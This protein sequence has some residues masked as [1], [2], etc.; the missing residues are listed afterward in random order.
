MLF[1]KISSSFDGFE[2]TQ[3]ALKPEEWLVV[4]NNNNNFQTW[5]NLGTLV[6]RK[7]ETHYC[8]A[9]VHGNIYVLV[10]IVGA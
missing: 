1:V 10:V 5:E 7:K 2:L 6:G 9:A 4:V 8:S 3:S